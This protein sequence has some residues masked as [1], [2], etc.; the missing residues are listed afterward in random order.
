V[1]ALVQAL[2]DQVKK[3]A[4]TLQAKD[5][6]IQALILELAHLRRLRYGVK[7]EALSVYSGI[8]SRKL[9]RRHCGAY[10]RSRAGR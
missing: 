3:D 10:G 1:A 5:L 7:N 2:L 4:E 8:Y 6:K 9:Q